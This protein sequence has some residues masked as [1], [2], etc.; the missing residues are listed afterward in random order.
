MKQKFNLI[1]TELAIRSATAHLAGDIS[2]LSGRKDKAL[3]SF[4][5]TARDLETIN[6]GLAVRKANLHEL[7]LFI[8]EQES[9]A[10]Q[11]IADNTAVRGRILDIIGE[12][13]KD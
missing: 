11:M 4:R 6:T 10:D 1:P 2:F 7:A 3:S 12:E 9:A 13:K 8:Q 5:K